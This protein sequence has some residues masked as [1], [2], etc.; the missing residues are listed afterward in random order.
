MWYRKWPVNFGINF[1]ASQPAISHFRELLHPTEKRTKTSLSYVLL[2]FNIFLRGLIAHDFGDQG[3]VIN[4]LETPNFRET[5]DVWISHNWTPWSSLTILMTWMMLFLRNVP[6][7][8][9]LLFL[10]SVIYHLLQLLSRRVLSSIYLCPSLRS[11][12]KFIQGLNA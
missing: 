9:Q 6:I 2:M 4:I 10:L 11:P 5:W 1:Q 7:N 3:V 12:I 8:L